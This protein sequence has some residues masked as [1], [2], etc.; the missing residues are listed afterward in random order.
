MR[1]RQCS[2]S[3]WRSCKFVRAA[4]KEVERR[5]ISRTRCCSTVSAWW[6]SFSR[7]G[8]EYEREEGSEVS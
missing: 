1:S 7:R 3:V 5:E 4:K 6:E 8:R 2:D